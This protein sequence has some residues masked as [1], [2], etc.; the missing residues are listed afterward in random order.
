MSVV[1]A[2]GK[3]RDRVSKADVLDNGVTEDQSSRGERGVGSWFIS[4]RGD[5]SNNRSNS[6]GGRGEGGGWRLHSG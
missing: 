3:Q 5:R 4:L 1:V 6:D 2:P